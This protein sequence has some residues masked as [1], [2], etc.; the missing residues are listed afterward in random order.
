MVPVKVK[1]NANTKHTATSSII[2][3]KPYRINDYQTALLR[4]GKIQRKGSGDELE[5]RSVSL[6]ARNAVLRWE[7]NQQR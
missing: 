7:T 1:S 4:A 2:D 6:Q 5:I 3:R